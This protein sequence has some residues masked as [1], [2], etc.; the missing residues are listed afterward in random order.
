LKEGVHS[1]RKK[2]TSDKTPGKRGRTS[3]TTFFCNQM[4]WILNWN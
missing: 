3:E 4:D 1:R 2:S